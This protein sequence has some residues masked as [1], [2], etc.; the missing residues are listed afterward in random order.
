VKKVFQIFLGVLAAIGGFVDIGELVANTEAGARYGLALVWPVLVGVVVMVLYAEMSGR[1][2][3]LSQRPVFDLVRERLGERAALANLAGSVGVNFLTMTAEMAGVALSFQLAADVSYLLWIPLVA[4][5]VW[6]VIWKVKFSVLENAVGI[7]GLALFAF[8]F[9]VWHAHPDWHALASQAAR[10]TVPHGEGHPTY[11]YWA[12]AVFGGTV[13]P[14]ELLFFSSGAVEERWTRED[15][16]L[17][18]ANVYLG[19]PLGALAA[20]SIMAAATVMLHP[21]NIEVTHLDQ[22]ALPVSLQLGKLGLAV[23]LVGFVAATF[24]AALETALANGYAVSQFFGWSWGKFVPPRR[25]PLF[26]VVLFVSI[27]GATML[28]LTTIDPVKI[29]EYAIVFSAVALP[30]TYVPVILVANDPDYVGD[31][32]NSKFSNAAAMVSLVV[33]IVAAVAAIPLMI[34]TKAGA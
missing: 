4:F 30:L 19:F 14:Y 32:T 1:I 22:A 26:H 17:N 2:A 11:F 34:A 20:I 23:V 15:L 6:L 33:V 18:R 12:V 31:K 7:A 13:M 3:T 10:P 9:A 8:A 27:V 28:G 16:S 29:T 25:A 21:F 5:F 24:G